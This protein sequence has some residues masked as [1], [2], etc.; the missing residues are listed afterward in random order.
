MDIRNQGVINRGGV[1][2][3]TRAEIDQGLRSYM[4]RVY[5]YMALGVALTG[6]VAWAVFAVPALSQLFFTLGAAGKPV[7]MTVLGWVAVFA[8]L[9]IVLLFS[10]R[11]HKMS[12]ASAQMVFWIFAAVMGLSMATIFFRFTGISIAKTFFITAAAFGALSLYGYTTKK[13]LSGWG[14]FLFIGLIGLIL[15][16]IVN[17][18][19]ASS[20]LGFAISAIGVL[21]F[22]GLTAYDTQKIKNMYFEVSGSG[23]MVAKAAIIGALELYLDFINMFQFLLNFLGDRD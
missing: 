14:T 17:L 9:A 1:A 16:S 12:A 19:L 11:V 13:D 20:A 15:A 18:F 23:E 2:T 8:P 10:F 22:A 21:I 3:A 4:L 6:A 5:N 7:G